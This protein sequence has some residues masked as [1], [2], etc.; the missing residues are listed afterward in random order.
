[1]AGKR[2]IKQKIPVA[3]ILTVLVAAGILISLGGQYGVAVNSPAEDVPM[4]ASPA[5][6]SLAPV[7]PEEVQQTVPE[8]VQK[9]PWKGAVPESDPVEDTYFE[10]VAFLGDSRTDGLRLYSGLKQGTYF[11]A[12]G[13]TVE[14]VF[15]K[16]VW[17]T[18]TGEIPLLSALAKE[19]FGKIYIMLGVNELGWAGTDIFRDQSIKL[20]QQLQ[21]DHPR[22]KIVIQSIF[23][24]SAQQDA[25]KSY[26]NNKRIAEYNAVWQGIAEELDVPYLNV[27][28]VLTGE[29]GCL[30]KAW[31]YDGVHLNK[32]GCAVWLD[33]LRTH[34]VEEE[35]EG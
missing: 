14:S 15:T 30:P 24:V 9:E 7:K 22:A 21:E 32:K 35:T 18:S 29:D 26:V 6:E 8:E 10:D 4:E 2:E 20:I 25:Q 3:G 16:N 28:E 34:A 1:M 17:K 19:E 5:E 27:A 23:P 13:T 11:C 12:T 33:Y 31:T